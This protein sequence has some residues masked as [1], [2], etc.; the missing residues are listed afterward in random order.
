MKK[1]SNKVSTIST[2]YTPKTSLF[3]SNISITPVL[4]TV[5]SVK[6]TSALTVTTSTGK[7]LQE[8]LADKQKQHFNFDAKNSDKG[9]V[10]S[11]SSYSSPSSSISHAPRPS[12]SLDSGIS[13]SQVI[14]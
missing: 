6:P 12:F 13:I 14:F 2:D 8:K 1:F 3:G 10:Q 4:Q 5:S 7:T 9:K 11:A